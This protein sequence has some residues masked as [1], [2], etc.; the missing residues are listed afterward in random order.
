MGGSGTEAHFA[1][2]PRNREILVPALY[3][4]T[5][6]SSGDVPRLFP[7]SE[8]EYLVCVSVAALPFFARPRG[9]TSVAFLRTVTDSSYVVLDHTWSAL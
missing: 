9:R 7:I 2:A 1:Q 3:H 6:Q 4:L 5:T 8:F